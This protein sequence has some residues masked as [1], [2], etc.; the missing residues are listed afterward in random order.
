METE[1]KMKNLFIADLHFGHANAIRF[2][3]RPWETVE[4]MDMGL[5]RRWNRKV[6]PEDHVYVLGDFAFKNKTPVKEYADQMNGTIH[7]IRGN[8]DKR[9]E[10]YQQCFYEILD[11]LEM[12]EE[13]HGV[14]CKLILSHY[15]IPF[16]NGAKWNAFM[17]HGHT[18]ISPDSVI[19]ERFKED[20]RAQGIRCE[21]YNVGCM[22]QDFEPQTFE[23]IL[24][25]QGREI[26][27]VP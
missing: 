6:Q 25:R 5:I 9:N 23:E 27:L 20:L 13:A 10:E 19:E 15:F 22:W 14:A 12:T 16:Y 11:Y 24:D 26:P 21:A 8:H 17:L 4:E 18:H 7:L 3:N 1:M 2:D